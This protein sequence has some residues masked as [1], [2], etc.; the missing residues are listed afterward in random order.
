[1]SSPNWYTAPISYEYFSS[2]TTANYNQSLDLRLSSHIAVS[3]SLGDLI[4]FEGFKS[5]NLIS[6]I[7]DYPFLD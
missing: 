6:Q 4:I 7:N 2:F 3:N 5:V 1:M